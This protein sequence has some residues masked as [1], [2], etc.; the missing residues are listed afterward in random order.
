MSQALSERRDRGER[1]E[2]VSQLD[3]MQ[4]MLDQAFGGLVPAALL[5]DAPWV[6]AVDIDEEEDA[7]VIHADVPGVDKKDVNIELL[8]NELAITGEIKEREKKGIVRRR[9]RRVGRF[10][11]RVA[12]PEQVDAE[13]IDASLKEGVLTVRVPKSSRAQRRQ[14][15]VKG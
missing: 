9:T 8:G 6:P 5:A 11:F 7:Y 15:E 4:R 14:I 2:P 3:L 12:L 13:K 1:S 10:E